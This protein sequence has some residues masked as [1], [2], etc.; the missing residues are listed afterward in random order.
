MRNVYAEAIRNIRNVVEAYLKRF[1]SIK[2]LPTTGNADDREFFLRLSIDGRSV[3][4]GEGHSAI[5]V[6]GGV[7]QK[8]QPESIGEGGKIA[9]LRFQEL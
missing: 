5:G 2:K 9:I 4:E 7:V 1:A 6:D 8:P 3:L